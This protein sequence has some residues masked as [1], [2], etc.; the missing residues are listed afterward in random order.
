ML[1]C[2]CFAGH[3]VPPSL[4]CWS[5]NKKFAKILKFIIEGGQFVVLKLAVVLH[6]YRSRQ[7]GRENRF[8]KVWKNTFLTTPSRSSP[9]IYDWTESK[10]FIHVKLSFK[11]IHTYIMCILIESSMCLPQRLQRN[12]SSYTLPPSPPFLLH[13]AT[14]GANTLTFYTAQ[15]DLDHWSEGQHNTPHDRALPF[16]HFIENISATSSGR[17]TTQLRNFKD[18]LSVSRE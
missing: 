17:F 10:L 2:F 4:R 14:G 8:D 7:E 5:K 3:F 6:R 16:S 9:D 1:L 12:Q 11:I 13:I 15:F 18:T